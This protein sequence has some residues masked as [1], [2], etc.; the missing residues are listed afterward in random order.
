MN[1]SHVLKLIFLK[2]LSANCLLFQLPC[3][4]FGEERNGRIIGGYVPP[5]H[6]IRYIVSIRRIGGDHFCGGSLVG[7]LWVLTAAHCNIGY[8]GFEIVAGEHNLTEYEG[9]EQYLYPELLIPH[10]NYNSAT[11]NHDLMLI[12]L[13]SPAIL[14]SFVSIVVLPHQDASIHEGHMCRVSGWG[15]TNFAEKQASIVLR[16]VNI[17]IISPVECNGS[18]SFNGHI[19]SKMLCAGYNDGGKDACKGDSGG[20]LVCEGRVYG[21]VS[22][23]KSCGEAHYPGVYTAVAQFRTWIDEAMQILSHT[24]PMV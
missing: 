7:T 6:T 24:C 23:G 3:Q 21:I 13:Q 19:T 8:D 12:K 10:P 9:T 15:Y 14:G 1:Q 5:A 18:S 11:N 16:T 20:P 22:W 4:D 2:L 17:P